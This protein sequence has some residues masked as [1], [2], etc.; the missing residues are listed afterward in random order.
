MRSEICLR[1][2]CPFLLKQM[3]QQVKHR[4]DYE[5][6]NNSKQDPHWLTQ[7]DGSL[8]VQG[9]RR[10]STDA[11]CTGDRRMLSCVCMDKFHPLTAHRGLFRFCSKEF[12]SQAL[13]RNASSMTGRKDATIS[14]ALNKKPSLTQMS[15]GFSCISD[16]IK[17]A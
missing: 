6:K 8:A 1:M 16:H 2:L 15:S 13:H 10:N 11:N 12:Q 3:N 9:V 4:A 14:K 7:R 5:Y 17:F